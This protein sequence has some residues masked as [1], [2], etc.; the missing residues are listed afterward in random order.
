MASW[1]ARESA[2]WERRR[3][4][5]RPW[6]DDCERQLQPCSWAPELHS[7]GDV[8]SPYCKER[9]IEKIL[10]LHIL[11]LE[12]LRVGE[13]GEILFQRSQQLGCGKA[14]EAVL[15]YGLW[16]QDWW[17]SHWTG[18]SP[19]LDQQTLVPIGSTRLSSL[20]R[21]SRRACRCGWREILRLRAKSPRARSMPDRML[22]YR[23]GIR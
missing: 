19:G 13:D 16:S 3:R 12:E 22:R 4:A 1:P 5:R 14:Y 8:A 7:L 20:N 17:T 6:P 18:T 2:S 21:R 23:A 11:E 9:K 10:P 15:C